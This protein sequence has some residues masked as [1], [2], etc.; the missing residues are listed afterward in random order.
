MAAFGFIE[1]I[2]DA[3]CFGN[4]KFSFQ[5]LLKKILIKLFLNILYIMKHNKCICNSAAQAELL[6][7]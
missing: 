7:W 2:T 1:D 3:K 5:S 6:W 4:L